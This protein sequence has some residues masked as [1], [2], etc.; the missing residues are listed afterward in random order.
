MRSLSAPEAN[1][2]RPIMMKPM[3]IAP[4]MPARDQP[5]SSAIGC[6]KTGSAKIAPIATQVIAAPA[7]TITQP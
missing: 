5:V 6:R 2:V 3:V 7:A 4:E 1:P